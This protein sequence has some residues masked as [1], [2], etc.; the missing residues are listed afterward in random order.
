MTDTRKMRV[1]FV[2]SFAS[3]IAALIFETVW[4]SL[5]GLAFG[6]S[7]WSSSLILASFMGGV[8][9]GNLFSVRFSRSTKSPLKL[10]IAVEMT[11]AISGFLLVLAFPALSRL[12]LPLFRLVTDNYFAINGL[13]FITA[14]SLLIVPAA[15]MGATLPVLLNA[16]ENS[17]EDYG[18]L[19]G[20]LYG[21]NTF[22]SVTGSLIAGYVLIRLFG[23]KGAGFAAALLNVFAAVSAYRLLPDSRAEATASLVRALPSCEI[24]SRSPSKFR[25]LFAGFL[26][27]AAMLALEVIWFRFLSIFFPQ[28][29]YIFGLMLAIILS[30]I[31]CGGFLASW[32][33]RANPGANLYLPQLACASG[34]FVTT[35]YLGYASGLRYFSEYYFLGYI[36]LML[37]VSLLSGIMFT[38][39]GES[40][41][42]WLESG[43]KT[44]GLLTFVNT[45]GAMAGS[46]VA[47]WLLIPA[48]GMEKSFFLLSLVYGFIAVLTM[49][50][51]MAGRIKKANIAYCFF[52]V[53]LAAALLFFPFGLMKKECLPFPVRS[54]LNDPMPTEV[55]A[56]REGWT[57]TIQYLQTR[58][59]TLP[60]YYRLVT[61]NYSMAATDIKNRRYMQMFTYLPM[62]LNPDISNALL[63]SFGT[64]STAKS[65]T[66]MGGIQQIDIVDI[67]KDI[68]ELSSVVYD[69]PKDNPLNDPRV[70][71]HLEDGR[72]YLQT[73]T[74]RFD[75][76]TSEPPPPWNYGV[77][78][79]YTQEHFQSIYNHLTPGGM[80]TYWLPVNQL[81]QAETV[82]I[83]KAFSN[84]FADCSV[85]SGAGFELIVLGRRP[86]CRPVTDKGIAQLWNNPA[87]SPELKALGLEYPEQLGTLL[88]ADARGVKELT[89][90]GLPLIDNYPLRLGANIF[91]DVD[92]SQYSVWQSALNNPE[93]VNAMPV[94]QGLLPETF[95]NRSKG[96]HKSQQII[97]DS[98]IES[99]QRP[100]Y[101]YLHYLL[102]ETALEA[103]VLSILYSDQD[104]Q[105]IASRAY[106]HGSTDPV[107]YYHLAI[108]YI[109]QRNYRSADK[110][111]AIYQGKAD[112]SKAIEM[113]KLRLYLSL[114]SKNT[115]QYGILQSEYNKLT[116]KTLREADPAYWQWLNVTFSSK[117]PTN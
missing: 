58:I 43:I 5:A 45:A 62:A 85:W 116:G 32:W 93:Q 2:A 98:L 89:R 71:V 100:V 23:I 3:G 102:S 90:D 54:H 64:G 24:T 94:D 96:Y 81:T 47:G 16:V 11:I 103:P 56:V 92:A 52:P 40:L 29:I 49:S 115:L 19:L 108:G 112:K 8:A 80:A 10:Y 111:L 105:R 117:K 69:S 79:L 28:H 106:S 70:T 39:L 9:L 27:G 6:N 68:L 20:R 87:V 36:L 67:S 51:E 113:Y 104:I 59:L 72:Y 84:V 76:I 17:R 1:L 77:V 97:N 57:E 46:L 63:I 65:L 82:S 14:L 33:L 83:L 35:S 109:A 7:V 31:S 107:M 101:E 114:L 50:R 30:G 61:N 110:F 37:P 13:R 66:G 88:L 60:Y 25:L 42:G 48:I 38:F 78:N 99:Y 73:T 86:P 18:R 34:I 75:L 55:V 4:F 22:G 44:T 95:W 15:A 26:S 41:C 53:L 74:K 91:S 21:W 12:M